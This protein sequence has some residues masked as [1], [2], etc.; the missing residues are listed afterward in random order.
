M[1]RS[2]NLYEALLDAITDGV[3][4]IHT[5]E[6]STVAAINRRL[7][8]MFDLDPLGSHRV[9]LREL[10]A[11]LRVPQRIRQQLIDAW[12]PLAASTASAEGHF[13]MRGV[14]GLACDI[15]WTS[16]PFFPAETPITTTD[17][18]PTRGR[19]FVFHDITAE[20]AAERLRD[21]LLQ[22]VSHELRTPLTAICG[23]AQMV[24]DEPALP[25]SAREYVGLI[26]SRARSL[27]LIVDDIVEINRAD[28]GKITLH[29]TP[30][31]LNDIMADV[32]SQLHDELQAS[33]QH[34]RLELDTVQLPPVHIDVPRI[35]QVLVNLISNAIRYGPQGG[36]I[37]VM[38]R[39]ITGPQQLPATAPPDVITPCV[40]LCVCDEGPGVTKDHLAGVFEPLYRAEQGSS[41]PDDGAGLGL[42]VARS[43]IALHRGSIWVEAATRRTPGGRFHLTLPIPHQ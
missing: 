32:A 27:R 40:L 18:A 37:H 1:E 14:N 41:R 24:L 4:L 9:P 43:L 38:T 21:D 29:R 17:T 7:I 30:A 19:I 35:T 13:T 22:R 15:H 8:A 20:N 3:I 31:Q 33:G 16:S 34:L 23:F 42:A 12:E 36:E 39:L 26:R 28:T 25:D 6:A 2:S 10:V 5:D 11:Q